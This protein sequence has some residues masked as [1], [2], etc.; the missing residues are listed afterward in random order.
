MYKAKKI[1]SGSQTKWLIQL[2]QKKLMLP[3]LPGLKQAIF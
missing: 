1:E 3:G 2:I